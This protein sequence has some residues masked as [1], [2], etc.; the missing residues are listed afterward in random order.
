MIS[1]LFWNLMGNQAATWADRRL[2]LQISI[3]RMAAAFE[4]DVFLFAESAFAIDEL[5]SVLNAGERGTYC[6]PP[7]NSDR[8]QLYTLLPATS[9]IDQFNDSS[10]GRL[11][12]RR[13]I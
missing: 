5:T 6:Y 9:V 8:I 7:S 4:V 13:L 11:T 12:I 3:A 2:N 1:F 10:D